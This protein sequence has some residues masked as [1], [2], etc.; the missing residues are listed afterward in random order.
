MATTADA[1]TVSAAERANGAKDKDKSVATDVTVLDIT[2]PNFMATAHDTYQALAAEGPVTRVK[3]GGFDESREADAAVHRGA[4]AVK[5]DWEATRELFDDLRVEVEDWID[6]GD[7]VLVFV[8]YRGRGRDS[9]AEVEASMA[10]V[11]TMRDGRAV[12]FRQFFDR[13]EARRAVES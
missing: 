5:R 2:D 13:D 1:K 4:E 9:G 10:H 12:R 6:A 11:W 8:R 7:D 3:F